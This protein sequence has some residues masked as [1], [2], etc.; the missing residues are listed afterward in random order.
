MSIQEL[1]IE[2]L[3]LSVRAKNALRM[4][5]IHTVGALVQQTEAQLGG[6]RNIGAKT[7]SE[8]SAKIDELRAEIA[9]GGDSQSGAPTA[10]TLPLSALISLPENR[11]AILRYAQLFDETIEGADLSNRAKNQLLRR[12]Y[13]HLSEVLFLSA[14]ELSRIPAM[15]ANSVQDVISYCERWLETHKDGVQA[16][17][18]GDE[19]AFQLPP[20]SDRE[21]QSAIL[22]L[23]DAE[24]YA[25]M[26]LWDFADNITAEITQ[27]Q[28]ERC[29]ERLCE[30][31]EMRHVNAHYCR[32]YPRFADVLAKCKKVNERNCELIVRRLNG[33]TLDAVGKDYDLTRERVRQITNKSLSK[34][35]ETLAEQLGCTLFAEDAY[36]YFYTTYEFD[37]KDAVQW[38]GIPAQ[39]IGYMELIAGKCGEAPLEDAQQDQALDVDLRCRIRDYLN[40]G[41]LCLDGQWIPLKRTALEKYVVE[42]FCIEEKTFDEFAQI[43]NAFLREQGVPYSEKLYLEEET[44]RARKA[45]LSEARFLLWKYGE[46]LRA[47]NIDG[48]DYS[49]LFAGLGLENIENT[50]LS[51]LKFVEDNPELMAR[52][53]IRDQYELHNLLRKVLPEGS[54][55]DLHIERSP[56]IRFGQFDRAAAFLEMLISNA[57]I[58]Q[59]DFAELIRKEYG[60]DPG[61]TI[62]TYLLPLNDYYHKGMY[63]IDQKTMDRE[64]REQLLRMLTDDFYLIDE[65]KALY[66]ERFPDADVLE[67]N[68]YNLKQ[69]GFTVRNRYAYRNYA[70]VEEYFRRLLTENDTLD[71]SKLRK[72]YSYIQTFSAVLTDLKRTLQV[73]EYE[74]NK[75]INARRLTAEGITADKI[76]AFCDAVYDSAADQTYFTITSIRRNGFESEIFSTNYPDWFY[77]N[78]L[79]SD[80]RFS[81]GIAYKTI[82]FYKGKAEVTIC[83]FLTAL[84][85]KVGGVDVGELRDMLE[86]VYG[87]KEPEE[88]DLVAKVKENGGFFC[89]QNHRIYDSED[90][91]WRELS[92]EDCKEE[93]L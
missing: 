47:Y 90:E 92:E 27:E 32:A 61:V 76:A 17:L 22:R 81:Y 71:I 77:A 59:S 20:P 33:E 37:K 64:K 21:L 91:Y 69:M 3:D 34:A 58:S 68:P 14:A 48:R 16:A 1:S 60:Y 41:K 8:I 44:F 43:Y 73:V 23:Y 7:I 51:T 40:R 30:A 38:L 83:S 19:Y 46:T 25:K 12:G 2:R 80:A 6:L 26:S 11:A 56:N 39:A 78:L 89:K 84:L 72:R 74:P 85:R 18:A 62:S 13:T 35:R 10:Q 88:S 28:I 9:A 65:L 75:L 54:F 86:T 36:R 50:E 45:R 52:F 66:T 93:Q 42:H 31:G 79:L 5:E 4:A 67:I 49:E 87:C 63:T 57:P 70:T 24:P 55:H 15:G 29:V 53:D 82:V